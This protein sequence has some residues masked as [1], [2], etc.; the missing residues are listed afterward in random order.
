MHT[1]QIKC[2]NVIL[3]VFYM[4]IIR[5]TIYTCSFFYGMFSSRIYVSS[6]ASGR[7]C[8]ILKSV[9]LDGLRYIIVPKC[10]VQKKT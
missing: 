6:L 5:K 7:L 9:H 10:T 3:G 4:F 1:F 2:P 8:S